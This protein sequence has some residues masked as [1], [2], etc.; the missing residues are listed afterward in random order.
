M[1]PT[2][3]RSTEQRSA[4]WSPPGGPRRAVRRPLRGASRRVRFQTLRRVNVVL[5]VNKRSCRRHVR[6]LTCNENHWEKKGGQ[7]IEHLVPWGESPRVSA[8]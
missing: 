6:L 7:N 2:P 8:S 4:R 1:E 5:V 3:S